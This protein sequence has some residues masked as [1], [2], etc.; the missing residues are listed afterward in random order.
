MPG[1]NTLTDHIM[2][3]IEFLTM[4]DDF[5]DIM[6]GDECPGCLQ[7]SRSNAICLRE[8][9][10]WMLF[11]EPGKLHPATIPWMKSLQERLK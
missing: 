2:F 3:T 4:C 10:D 11:S 8:E 1:F 5:K 9:C 6:N 7:D